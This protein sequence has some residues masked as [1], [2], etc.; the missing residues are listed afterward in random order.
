MDRIKKF[1]QTTESKNGTY[2]IGLT[3]LVLIIVVIVNLIIGQLPE[4]IRN[5]DV[6]S[7]QLYEISDTT[8]ELLAGLENDVE[9]VVLADKDNTDERIKTFISKY[10]ALSKYISVEWI[11]PVLHPSALAEYD[12]SENTI[13]VSCEETGKTMQVL[14]DDILVIDYYSYYYTGTYTESE[15]D[16]DGQLTSAV[17][18]VTSG[19]SQTIYR[20]AGHGESTL[21]SSVS[22]LISKANYT[23]SEVNLL[24]DATIPENCDLLLMYAPTNDL[25]EVEIEAI[26]DYMAEGGDVMLILADV[27]K[28]SLPNLESFMQTYGLAM[29]DG[30]IADLE[31]CY[32][33]NYYYIFPSLSLSTELASG[34]SSEMVLMAYARGMEEVDPARDTISVDTFMST[35]TNSYAVTETSETQGEYILGAIATESIAAEAEA[36]ES[37]TLENRLTVISSLSIIDS[38]LTDAYPTLENLTVFMNAV[39]ANF[40]GVQNVSIEPKSL[41][42]EYNT[43]QYGGWLSLFV[44][45]GVPVAVLASGFVVWFKRRRA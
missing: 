18:Y 25:A 31:R 39:T 23:V 15:F 3:A 1:F 19:E 35:S 44:I 7:N 8:K 20:T 34:I 16:G 41:E 29:A 12:A 40:D 10:S 43:V 27:D 6:S 9:M 37:E 45:F 30:Y 22:D 32:Q 4:S 14:F 38:Q 5:I 11:D 13:V 36:S 42:M 21:S 33:G 2:S 17:N 28:G 24:M 26:E